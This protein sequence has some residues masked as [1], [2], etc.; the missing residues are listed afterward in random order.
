MSSSSATVPPSI[1][2]WRK[3]PSAARCEVS[4]KTV[5]SG[6]K[7]YHQLSTQ[8]RQLERTVSDQVKGCIGTDHSIFQVWNGTASM[9]VSCSGIVAIVH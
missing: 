1:G 4:A 7:E 2:T 9:Q 8:F 5:I 6:W 3:L